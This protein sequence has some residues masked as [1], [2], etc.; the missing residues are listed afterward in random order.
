MQ[1][2]SP[3]NLPS[4]E[5]QAEVYRRLRALGIECHLEHRIPG[6]AGYRKTW[7]T[8]VFDLVV[9]FDWKIVAIVECKRRLVDDADRDSR[10]RTKQAAAYRQFG[11]PLFWCFGWEE[12]QKTVEEVRN[13]LK[14]L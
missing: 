9:V 3:R 14:G 12:I 11:I 4:A 10:Q 6:A 5:V 2:V 1:F 8:C 13:L 7:R